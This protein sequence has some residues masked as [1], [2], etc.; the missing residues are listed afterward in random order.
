MT[1]NTR[2]EANA[3]E[4][5]RTLSAVHPEHD[6]PILPS[7]NELERYKQVDSTD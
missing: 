7:A 2:L 1:K 3:T 6:C 4:D 5:T